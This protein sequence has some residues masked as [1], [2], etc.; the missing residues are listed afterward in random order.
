LALLAAEDPLLAPRV[1]SVAAV[2]PWAAGPNQLRLATTGFAL[3]DGKL[4]P[5]K[6]DPALALYSTRS[7]VA[8]LGPST[9]REQLLQ[10]VPA[11]DPDPLRLVRGLA[12]DSLFPDAAAVVHLLANTRRRRS[13]RSTRTSPPRSTRRWSTCPR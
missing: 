13:T 5:Y 12:L 3:T 11:N 10:G 2:A 8:A 4:V 7:L 1:T 9:D 6:T